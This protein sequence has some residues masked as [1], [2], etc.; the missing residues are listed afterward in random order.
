[1]GTAISFMINIGGKNLYHAGD[2][3]MFG[4]MALISEQ[5]SIDIA[6]RSIGGLYTMDAEDAVRAEKLLKAKKAI[7]MHYRKWS[8]ADRCEFRGHIAEQG[9]GAAVVKRSGDAMIV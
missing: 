5:Y 3:A 6:M 7:P 4:D 1:M 8:E 2:T 9:I